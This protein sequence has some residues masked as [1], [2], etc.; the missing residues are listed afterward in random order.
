VTVFNHHGI[1]NFDAPGQRY[2]FYPYQLS[3][4]GGGSDTTI[5]RRTWTFE[6]DTQVTAFQFEVLVSAAWP[7]TEESRWKVDYSADS[8]PNFG[9]EPAWARIAVGAANTSQP[10][11]GMIRL[12]M[13]SGQS[14]VYTR[15]DS[16]GTAQNAYIEARL[17]VVPLG[18]LL[19]PEIS[20]GLDDRV[21]FIAVG[22]SGSQ[23][24][25]L[26]GQGTLAFAV[27]TA[28]TTSNF[29]TYRMRK[30]G[31]DSVVLYLNGT[32]L[33]HRLYSAFPAPLTSAPTHGFYFGPLGTGNGVSASGN[34][35]DWD[36]VIYEIGV[37]QP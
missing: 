25:F 29:Q 37:T 6:A 3:E 2:W 24:G 34:V 11:A 19:N 22:L 27:S 26:T 10:V 33:L 12:T 9:T 13:S 31:S 7:A 23:A 4:M 32:R 16:I 21:K 8:L 17:A 14:L 36:Y 18:I 35:S 1:Y 30:F 5:E 20:F 15:A 28:V